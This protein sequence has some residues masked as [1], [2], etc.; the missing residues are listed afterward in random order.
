M[1]EQ[2][3]RLPATPYYP[4]FYLAPPTPPI[5]LSQQLLHPPRLRLVR[6][7]LDLQLLDERELHAR[8]DQL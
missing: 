3:G 1:L 5:P 4:L 2:H 8:F 7:S 6:L